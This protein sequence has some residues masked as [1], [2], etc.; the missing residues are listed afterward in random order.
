MAARD[1]ARQ[2]GDKRDRLTEAAVALAYRQGYHQTTL[3]DIAT[4]SGVPVGNVYYYFKTKDDIGEAVLRHR[5]GEFDVVRDRLDSL[6]T[7]TARLVAFIDR[8]MA[9]ASQVARHGCPMGSL[10][11]EL[12]KN[13][14]PLAERA[15]VLLGRPMEWMEEQFRQLGETKEA[16]DLALQL[17]SSLQGASL[18]TQSLRNPSLLEREGARLKAWVLSFG[19]KEVPQSTK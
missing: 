10:S 19:G 7:P 6:P 2:G 9:N 16:G 5:Q 15:N 4:E 14:G 1:R 17:Q 11:A 3:T 13:G 12:L 18:L 8:T